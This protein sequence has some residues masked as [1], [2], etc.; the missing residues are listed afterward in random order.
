MKRSLRYPLLDRDLNPDAPRIA[1]KGTRRLL[2]SRRVRL[3]V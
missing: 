1:A 2:R 3:P